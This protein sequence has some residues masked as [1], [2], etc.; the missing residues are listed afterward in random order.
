[1]KPTTK[2]Y[3]GID[4]SKPYFDLSLM[5]VVNHQ[6]E[7]ILTQRFANTPAGIISFHN[8]LTEQ[9]VTF[10]EH[11]LVV[12]E[13]TGIYHR[14]LWQFCSR[15]NLPL[16][17]GN[18]AHIKWSFGIARGKSDLV[19][20]LRLCHYAHKHADELKATPILNSV[21]VTIK[22]LL[23]ARSKLVTQIN[24]IKTWLKEIKEMSDK[25]TQKLLEKAHKYA[26]QGLK[27]SVVVLEKE[28][29]K[30]IQE[31]KQLKAN[32]ELLLTVPGIGH[33]TAVYLIC[34]TNNFVCAVTGKQLACYAGV[35]PFEHTSGT[36]VRGRKK[37]HPMANEVLKKSLHLCALSAIKYY[38]EF[39]QYY[40]RKK[41][42]GKHS[43]SVL[44]AIKNKLVIR[45]VAVIN[46]QK[47]YVDYTKSAA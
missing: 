5:K 22:D 16:H 20:S 2:F 19:D 43:M 25:D 6:K 31:D 44:N 35:V 45:A 4:V 1:M 13:N 37:V 17:I 30:R 27:K 15:H 10:D 41:A 42:E 9:G 33:L 3:L 34:C 38:P 14:L 40:D 7:D 11:A 28:I 39:K 26:L 24:A 21:L 32:Y 12:I 8:W 46:Q 23:T 29:T 18:A 47:P 36:S